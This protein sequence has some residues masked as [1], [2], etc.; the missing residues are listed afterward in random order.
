MLIHGKGTSAA[1][2]VCSSVHLIAAP[3]SLRHRQ[4]HG[5]GA[6]AP[7]PRTRRTRANL[8]A[9]FRSFPGQHPGG[10][11]VLLGEAGKDATEAFEVCCLCSP[12]DEL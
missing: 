3:H 5:R 6:F 12:P 9:P 4:V 10:D 8:A 1:S 2:L 11:E 7:H